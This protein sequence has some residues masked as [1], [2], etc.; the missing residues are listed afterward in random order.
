MSALK[1]FVYLG[2]LTARLHLDAN[3][4]RIL[5]PSQVFPPQIPAVSTSTVYDSQKSMSCLIFSYGYYQCYERPSGTL[6]SDEEENPMAT[7]LS[8]ATTP[9]PLRN[10]RD[11]TKSIFPSY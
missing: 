4:Q 7:F 10:D 11:K 8:I 1:C 2:W 6:K 5:Q 9:K 3:N